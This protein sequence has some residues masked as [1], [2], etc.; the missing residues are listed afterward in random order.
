MR[1]LVY[2]IARIDFRYGRREDS[3]AWC[4]NPIF[5]ELPRI[6]TTLL[7]WAWYSLLGAWDLD[8]NP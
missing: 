3:A 6:G 8:D 1:E 4:G 2:C 7:H 5:Q